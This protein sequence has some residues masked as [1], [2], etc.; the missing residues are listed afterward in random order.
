[1]IF[2]PTVL[3]PLIDSAPHIIQS[4]WIWLRAT[5]FDRL[6]GGCDVRAILAVGH[7][8]LKL[9]APP[10]LCLRASACRIFPFGF[11]WESI[12]LSGRAREPSNKLLCITPAYVRDGRIIFSGRHEPTSFCGSAFIPFPHGNRKFA[13]SKR[14]Y[15]YLMHR[16]F[17]NIFIATHGEATATK[18]VHFRLTDRS[19][20]RS[21]WGYRRRRG[22][23]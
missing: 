16:L 1:M 14:L 13:D 7:A 3:D 12:S 17:R 10:V 2:V 19:E 21:G 6:L 22:L 4:K 20:L 11:A 23:L 15:S 18:R 8:G 5:D 9:V